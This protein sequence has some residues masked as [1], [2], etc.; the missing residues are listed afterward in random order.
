MEE[1]VQIL[2]PVDNTPG[3]PAEEVE[4][5][6]VAIPKVPNVLAG[7]VKDVHGK[8]LAGIL[9][10]IKNNH[11]DPVRAIKSNALGQFSIS[12]PLPNGKYKINIDVNK[13]TSLSFDIID[14]EAVGKI[15]PP[16]EFVGKA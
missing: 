9:L 5:E 15:I 12:N 8:G 11:G 14:V 2:R 3:V 6:T 7:I 16:L 13:E 4:A 1:K 10:I